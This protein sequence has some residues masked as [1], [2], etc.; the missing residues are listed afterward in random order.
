MASQ[1][2][3][4]YTP[5]IYLEI[6]RKSEF[7]N[8]Y[9]NGEILAMTGAS[10]KHNLITINIASSLNSQSKGRQCEVYASD[11]RV[12]VGSGGLY[13]YPDVVVVCGTPTFEDS[14]GDTLTNPTVIV[15]VLSKTTEGYDRGDKSAHYRRLDSLLEYVL[16][17]Q[18][19][20]HLE[21]FV[22]QHDNQWLLS[23]A[24]DLKAVIDLISIS[25]KLAL[26]D[27]Y[28]KVQLES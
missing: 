1:P 21:H 28:D 15:E 10:R 5:E 20:V 2:K 16:V 24:G 6:D 23:E 19:K 22:R 9:L 26:A 13:T 3:T 12:K 14:E 17:S 25:C 18:D 7:K 11:M 4:T 8:E 27:I